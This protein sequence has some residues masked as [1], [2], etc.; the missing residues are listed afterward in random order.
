M[1]LH[2][3]INKW[4]AFCDFLENLTEMFYS[5]PFP[6]PQQRCNG[7]WSH[8]F[9]DN[10]CCWSNC[11]FFY[12]LFVALAQMLNK[13]SLSWVLFSNLPANEGGGERCHSVYYFACKN[14]FQ[15]SSA[16]TCESKMSIFPVKSGCCNLAH[17][18]SSLLNKQKLVLQFTVQ[19]AW[20]PLNKEFS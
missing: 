1:Q 20:R 19:A 3:N 17:M 8:S 10:L 15:V 4:I 14:H 6:C 12:C 16:L 11:S 2:F 13:K 9:K 5:L 7:S 18:H